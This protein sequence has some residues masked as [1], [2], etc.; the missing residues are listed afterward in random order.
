VSGNRPI[1]NEFKGK[2]RVFFGNMQE[3]KRRQN[4]K[5]RRKD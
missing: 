2:D 4:W 3:K 5:Q 1:I